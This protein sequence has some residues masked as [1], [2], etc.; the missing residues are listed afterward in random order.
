MRTASICSRKSSR[1][2]LAGPD[3][4]GGRLGLLGVED[5]LGLFDQAQHVAH[6]QNAAGH[7]VRVE[8]VEVFELLPGGGEKDWHTGDFTHRQRGATAGVAVQL[9]QYHA[10][11]ADAVAER[12][13]G[14]DRVLADHR[15]QDEQHFVGV[16][17]VADGG[18]L[19]HQLLV[20]AQAP[21]GVD[22][23]EV[24]VLGLGLGDAGGR[25]GDRVARAG[26]W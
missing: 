19:R 5:L 11:E 14:G 9:G 13:G 12:L 7:P 21:R 1:G 2:E 20:D 18:G 4:G 3:L 16:D 25:D 23:D 6:A 24:E 8:D 22:D 17:G 10:G 26:L 15:V